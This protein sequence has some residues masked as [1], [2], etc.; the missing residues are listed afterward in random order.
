MAD[1]K[2]VTLAEVREMMTA[3]H[4]KRGGDLLPSQKAAMAH[5]EAI[6]PISLEQAQELTQKLVDLLADYDLENESVPVKIVDMLPKYPAD[7]RAIFSKEK[8]NLDA[9]L[10]DRILET[11]AEYL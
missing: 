8:V 2:Y 7:V 11:V 1:G 4:M 9:E 5:A 6:C 10:T 3:E